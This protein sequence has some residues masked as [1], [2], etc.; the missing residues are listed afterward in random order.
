M[1]S[2]DFSWFLDVGVDVLSIRFW[3]GCE[4]PWGVGKTKEGFGRVG[5]E[6]KGR[7]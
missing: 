2:V 7:E 6:E 4:T 5:D 3:E 1:V